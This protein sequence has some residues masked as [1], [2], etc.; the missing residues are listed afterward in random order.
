MIVCNCHA[1]SDR[2]IIER[3]NSG[4]VKTHGLF[5]ALGVKHPQCGKCVHMVRAMLAGDDQAASNM[6]YCIR[7]TDRVIPVDLGVKPEATP[8]VSTKKTRNA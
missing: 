8:T 2:E 3:R 1:I 7:E 5:T 4:V 6:D